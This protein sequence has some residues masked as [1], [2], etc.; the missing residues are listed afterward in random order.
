MTHTKEQQTPRHWPMHGWIGLVLVLVFW[1][2]NWSLTGLRTHWG[3]FPLWLG[4]IGYIVFAW[5]LHALYLF[6]IGV[7]RRGADLLQICPV[8]TVPLR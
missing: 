3:F 4:Y 6:L 2:L 1:W 5:E 7:F 8:E